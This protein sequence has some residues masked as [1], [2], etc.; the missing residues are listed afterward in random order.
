[1]TGVRPTEPD[2]DIDIASLFVSLWRNKG[3][4]LVGSL[5]AA[6]LAYGA[7]LVVTPKYTASARVFIQK[8]QSEYTRP[9]QERLGLTPDVDQLGVKSQ[10]EIIPASEVLSKVAFGP[11]FNN[12]LDK[13]PEFDPAKRMSAIDSLLILLS[14]KN[15]PRMTE[16]RG[17]IVAE[18]RDKL[19]VYSVENSR[20]LVVEFSSSDRVLAAKIPN[21][22][23]VAYLELLG[24]DKGQLDLDAIKKLESEIE[25]LQI[26][27]RE[28]ESKVASYRSQ[29]DILIG[30]NN[31]ALAT[32]Q[33]SELSTELSRVRANRANSQAKA[34][35]VRGVLD[36]GT[37][38]D[39]LPDVVASGLIQR[40]RERQVQLQS[41]IAELSTTM[42]DGHPRIQ[43]LRSQ[44]SNLQKQIGTEARN[45]LESLEADARTAGLREAELVR[46]LN[47]LKAESSRVGDEEVKLNELVREAESQKDLLKERMSSYRDAKSRRT[48]DEYKPAEGRVFRAELPVEPYFPKK[49]PIVTAAFAGALLLLS[50]LTMLRELFSGRAFKPVNQIMGEDDRVPSFAMPEASKTAAVEPIGERPQSSLMSLAPEEPADPPVDPEH[51][52]KAM[53]DRLVDRGATRA[54]IVSPEGDEGAA[55]SVLITREMADRGLRSILLDLTQTG[56]AS[57]PMVDGLALPGITNLLASQAQFKDIIQNDPYSQAHVIPNGTADALAA[58]KAVER[59]PIILNALTTAYDVVIVECGPADAKGIGRLVTPGSEII[60]SVIDPADKSIVKCAADLQDAGYED[61]LIVTPVGS[62]PTAPQ[63][64]RNAA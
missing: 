25:E 4:I 22:I 32:Q 19:K 43:A 12:N 15:D 38:I 1:M 48:G 24:E 60:I 42:L 6:G 61:L 3:K 62:I 36:D 14:L 54:I 30:Q 31:S 57:H 44:L 27:V 13:L 34:A 56:A 39:A 2:V 50:L 51:T 63:P 9:N 35:S 59:L 11:E 37:S 47:G 21:D 16:E 10:V 55:S 45:I 26:K 64:N 40:L 28:A 46:N 33:L 7:T 23:A 49:I 17:R 8:Q 41:E 52:V 20:T 18:M 53:C 58:M 29:S 5:A